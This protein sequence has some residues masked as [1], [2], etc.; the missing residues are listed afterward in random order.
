MN[1]SYVYTIILQLKQFPTEAAH[2]GSD[3]CISC[4]QKISMGL[5]SLFSLRLPVESAAGSGAEREIIE[6]RSIG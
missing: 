1:P 5:A 4:L 3:Y 6:T 2:F